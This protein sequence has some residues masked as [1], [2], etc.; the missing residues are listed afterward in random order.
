MKYRLRNTFFFSLLLVFLFACSNEEPDGLLPGDTKTV[1]FRLMLSASQEENSQNTTQYEGMRNI[2]VVITDNDGKILQREEEDLRYLAEMNKP[3]I[4]IL[5]AGGPVELTDILEQT[6]N[7]K[8]I[9]NI[10]QLG[11]EGGDALADVN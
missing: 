7:I 4:L 5:N 3:V 6:D 9:L 11:Q 1:D 8:G 2:L 10:S